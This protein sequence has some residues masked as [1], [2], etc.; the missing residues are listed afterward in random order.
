[1]RHLGGVVYEAFG[2]GCVCMCVLG[3]GGA[4]LP[5]IELSS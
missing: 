1:M 5:S 2:W 4:S 3:L